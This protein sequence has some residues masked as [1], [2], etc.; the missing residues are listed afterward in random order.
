MVKIERGQHRELYVL[1]ALLRTDLINFSFCHPKE[2][3]KVSDLLPPEHGGAALAAAP[4]RGRLTAKTRG[5]I[6]NSF[7]RMMDALAENR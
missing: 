3:V 7:R 4:Q 6:A 1:V 5:E 2:P